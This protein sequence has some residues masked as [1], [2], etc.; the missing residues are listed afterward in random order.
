MCSYIYLIY[1][2]AEFPSLTSSLALGALQV[3]SSPIKCQEYNS[4]GLPSYKKREI[5]LTFIYSS[6]M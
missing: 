3:S 1:S 6:D 4:E 2:I 5:A